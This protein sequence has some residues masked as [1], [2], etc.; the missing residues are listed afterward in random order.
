MHEAREAI[1]VQCAMPVVQRMT[2]RLRNI[3]CPD[4]H[5]GAAELSTETPLMLS[6][7]P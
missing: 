7:D 5:P 2:V 1:A 4:A 6:T 3:F